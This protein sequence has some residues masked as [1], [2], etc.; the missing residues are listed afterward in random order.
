MVI[1]F[2]W[3]AGGSGRQSMARLASFVCDL[4]LFQIEIKRNY[5]ILEFREDLKILYGIVGVK[6]TPS[7]FLFS[8]TQVTFF[9]L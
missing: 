4:T 9:F 1:I 3:N 7:C 6:D 8:D 5:G 2:I